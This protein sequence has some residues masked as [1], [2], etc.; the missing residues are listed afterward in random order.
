MRSTGSARWSALRVTTRK[1]PPTFSTSGR[2]RDEVL[3]VRKTFPY[4]QL[5][6]IKIGRRKVQVLA[7]LRPE[8]LDPLAK[9]P[10]LSKLARRIYEIRPLD[11]DA[12]R[13]VI[14]EPASVA[15]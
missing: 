5:S 11:S 9:D 13:S 8:F 12:L 14:E 7:T 4:G 2:P 10:D 1:A 15:G 3:A 6:T